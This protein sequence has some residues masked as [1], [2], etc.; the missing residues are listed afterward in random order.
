MLNDF[1]VI[2]YLMVSYSLLAI[3]CPQTCF[4]PTSILELYEPTIGTKNSA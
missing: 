2:D 1:E 3:G 4:P